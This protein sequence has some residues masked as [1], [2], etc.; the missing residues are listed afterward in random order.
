[1]KPHVAWG[2]GVV[3]KN[4]LT[5]KLLLL[6]EATRQDDDA[7]LYTPFMAANGQSTCG[8]DTVITNV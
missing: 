5:G 8:V 7:R 4:L 2:A 3:E 6:A 1:M